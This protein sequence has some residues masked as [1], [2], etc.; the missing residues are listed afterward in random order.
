[1]HRK[2][3]GHAGHKELALS[4]AK[5]KPFDT[6]RVVDLLKVKVNLCSRDRLHQLGLQNVGLDDN[7]SPLLVHCFIL[8]MVGLGRVSLEVFELM[9]KYAAP[10]L[11]EIDA[12]ILEVSLRIKISLYGFVA[13]GK[14]SLLFRYIDDVF[15]GS[16][17][18]TIGVD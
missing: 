12:A 10:D 4:A 8:A 5:M 11:S 3:A 17:T 7:I 16:T 2:T 9:D 1:M 14:T 13:T 18:S 6:S 15:T